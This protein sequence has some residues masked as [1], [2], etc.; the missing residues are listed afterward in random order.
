MAARARTGPSFIDT[1][2]DLH[3]LDPDEIGLGGLGKRDSYV[4]PPA[5]P[6]VRVVERLQ[7]RELPDV[8]RLHDF[9]VERLPEQTHGERRA[10]RLRAAQL[11]GR[12]RRATSPPSSTGRSRPWATRWPTSPTASTLGRVTGGDR[13]RGDD[14][15]DVL[16]GFASP[17]GAARPLRRRARGADL[18]E[19]DYYRCFNHW[20]SVC[21]LQGVYARYLHGQKAT[22]A[23]ELD[24]FPVRIE[25]SL[26][27][28]ME[29]AERLPS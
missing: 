8:D 4:G 18:S 3:S 23:V 25:R 20:K 11:P 27:L 2:A 9:L 12:L 22:D 29:A 24:L 19:I 1:L 21:I 14:A 7:D 6:L 28:A 16:P 13:R 17:P 5:A 10:R 26:R 15:H